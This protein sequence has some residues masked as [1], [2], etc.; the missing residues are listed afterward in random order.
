MTGRGIVVEVTT[1]SSTEPLLPSRASYARNLSRANDKLR[2]FR[3]CLRWMCIDQSEARHIVVS[4]SLF[5]LL[6]IFV[7]TASHFIISCTP[8]CRTHNVV[9]R[10]SLT[11]ASGLSYLYLSAFV[12]RYGLRRFLFLDKLVEE[13][14]QVQ[15][16]YMDQINHSFRLLSVFVMPCFTREV[17]YKVWWYSLRSEWV[18]FAVTSSAMVG[19]MVACTLELM[20]DIQKPLARRQGGRGY[21]H[22]MPC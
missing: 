4:C 10:L 7:S 18:S 11:S 2:S 6:G 1:S 14:E 22:T 15:E 16:G 13:S 12:C 20:S 5:L 21:V 19:D 8:T 17:A 3:F 9:V